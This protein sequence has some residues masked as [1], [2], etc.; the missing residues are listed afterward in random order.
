MKNTDINTFDG[1]FIIIKLQYALPIL[2]DIYYRYIIPT[3]I[4]MPD[5]FF[6][7]DHFAFYGDNGDSSISQGFFHF[8]SMCYFLKICMAL[9]SFSSFCINF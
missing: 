1:E 5:S 3:C 8:M 2:K 7:K 6:F 4:Y 9:K